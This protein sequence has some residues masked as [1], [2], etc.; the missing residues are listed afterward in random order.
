MDM[1][2]TGNLTTNKDLKERLKKKKKANKRS[3]RKVNDVTD[4]LESFTLNMDGGE[5]EVENY[6]F[7]VDFD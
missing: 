4:V 7:K 6:D 3:E 2:F 1:C 5:G